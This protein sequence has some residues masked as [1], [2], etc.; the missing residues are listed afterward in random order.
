MAQ[1]FT[2]GK[3]VIAGVKIGD[4]E[5]RRDAENGETFPTMKSIN[6]MAL[7][8]ISS[9]LL[10]AGFSQAAQQLDPLSTSVAKLVSNSDSCDS[11]SATCATPCMYQPE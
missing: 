10:S 1:R 8:T 2:T 3:N 11:P 5:N 6:R 4:L 9:I 7:G